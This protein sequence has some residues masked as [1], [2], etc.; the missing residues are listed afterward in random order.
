[1]KKTKVKQ[2]QLAQEKQHLLQAAK[3]EELKEKQKKK[4]TKTEE[5]DHVLDRFKKK[6][7]K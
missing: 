7:K 3:M 4:K 5:S 2:L 1:M 6:P